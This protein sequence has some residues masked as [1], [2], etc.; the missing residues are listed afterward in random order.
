MLSIYETMYLADCQK[1]AAL[2]KAKNLPQKR[3]AIPD[4]VNCFSSVIRPFLIYIEG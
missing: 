1:M 2:M 3:K 4:T